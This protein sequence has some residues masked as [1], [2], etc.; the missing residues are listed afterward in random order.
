MAPNMPE[1]KIPGRRLKTCM[2]IRLLPFTDAQIAALDKTGG[3]DWQDQLFRNAS[4]QM[5][6][7]SCKGWNRCYKILYCR[8][9]F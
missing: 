5:H 2:A 7:I 6:Q 4:L 3:T 9:L 8:W 1:Y